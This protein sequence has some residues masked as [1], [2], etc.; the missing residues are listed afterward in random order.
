MVT[1]VIYLL[2]YTHNFFSL[3]FGTSA[4]CTL[5]RKQTLTWEKSVLHSKKITMNPLGR[6]L[7]KAPFN[8]HCM[9]EKFENTVHDDNM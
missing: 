5:G 8:L 2:D 9:P 1:T 4:N 7:T 6:P 3:A